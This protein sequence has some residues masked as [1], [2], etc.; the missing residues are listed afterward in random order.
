MTLDDVG[1]FLRQMPAG[2]GRAAGGNELHVD[3][4]G[5][6]LGV[7]AL[8]DDVLDQPVGGALHR[9]LVPFHDVHPFAV[10]LTELPRRLEGLGVEIDLAAAGTGALALDGGDE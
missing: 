7:H 1:H 10:F 6:L 3:V 5:A 2:P 8:V 4:D 9:H